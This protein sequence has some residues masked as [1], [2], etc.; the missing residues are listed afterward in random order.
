MALGPRK[1]WPRSVQCK[2]AWRC[3]TD[4]GNT[5][6]YIGGWGCGHRDS[7]EWDLGWGVVWLLWNSNTYT[8]SQA[9]VYLPNKSFQ[10]NSCREPCQCVM[11]MNH[12]VTRL[13]RRAHVTLEAENF[14]RHV[15][16]RF[17]ARGRT[18]LTWTRRRTQPSNLLWV[19]I[20]SRD[21][22]FIVNKPSACQKRPKS[23]VL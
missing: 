5:T 6:P 10:A 1:Q 3:L 20:P 8:A 11:I 22:Y 13:S 9:Q 19:T 21:Q 16:G 15:W 2:F 4:L 18:T 7:H 23:L 17:T 14:F 12:D